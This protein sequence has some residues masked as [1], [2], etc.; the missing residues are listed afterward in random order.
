MPNIKS[1]HLSLF[2]LNKFYSI[3]I[4][5]GL[6]LAKNLIPKLFHFTAIIAAFGV[7]KTIRTI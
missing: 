5:F 2:V 1:I 4:V 3:S 7:F 6:A